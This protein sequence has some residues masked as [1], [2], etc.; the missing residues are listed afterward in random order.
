MI[1]ESVTLVAFGPYSDRTQELAPG[2]NVICGLNESGKSTWHA[3]VYAALC[4]ISRASGRRED[5]EFTERH[6]PWDQA[7]WEVR[8]VVKLESGRR[9]ELVQKLDSSAPSQALDL[10]SGDD[11]SAEIL[12][13]GAPDGSR[14]LGF[15]RRSFRS[16]ACVAQADVLALL[17]EPALLQ[18]QLTRA[19]STAGVESSSAAASERLDGLAA[20]VES[21][22]EVE[23]ERRPRL[24]ADVRQAKAVLA[25]FWAQTAVARDLRARHADLERDLRVLEAAVAMRVA[26]E[27]AHRLARVRELLDRFPERPQTNPADAD[28]LAQ[29]VA[30][31]IRAFEDRPE[32]PR[33]KGATVAELQHELDH[34]PEVAVEGDV[35][36]HPSVLAAREAYDG[37]KRALDENWA[38]RPPEPEPLLASAGEEELRALAD[39]LENE[40]PSGSASSG[41]GGGLMG[42]LLARSARSGRSGAAQQAELL[43]LPPHP[44]ALRA[45]AD[46]VARTQEMRSDLQ[47]WAT[48]QEELRGVVAERESD[49][50][51]A[52][53]A[54]GVSVEGQHILETL[55]GYIHSCQE[56]A[57]TARAEARRRELKDMIQARQ[58]ADRAAEVAEETRRRA[59]KALREV[60]VRCGLEGDVDLALL[61]GLHDWLGRHGE[62][63]EERLLCYQAWLELDTLIGSASVDEIEAASQ[64]NRSRALELAGQADTEQLDQ[65]VLGPEADTDLD[66]L[67]QAVAAALDELEAAEARTEEVRAMLAP[68]PDA[69]EALAASDALSS[70]LR[71]IGAAATTAYDHL[72]LAQERVHRSVAPMLASAVK[73]WLPAITNGRYVD[74]WVQPET[75]QVDVCGTDRNWRQATVLSHGT[76]EQIYLLL[77]LAMVERL[78]EPGERA[79]VLLDDVT[80][81]SDKPRTLA[82]LELLHQVSRERQVILFSQ[83]DDVRAWAES[84]LESRDRLLDLDAPGVPATEG[85]AR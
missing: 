69:E 43:G 11:I 36:P 64:R 78:T 84:H 33:P 40:S 80:V 49:L 5:R 39:Q 73:Q 57:A 46:H 31:A 1:I 58:E 71:E 9:V 44:A 41:P 67:R 77:R 47:R 56:R 6:R 61:A 55:F 25:E 34:L 50:S 37:A 72:A 45:A 23:R 15:N 18:E 19:A 22:L 10:A 2:F 28:E 20:A 38:Q 79:P 13:E 42:R 59:E 60:A 62:E 16:T 68:I 75:L 8:A 66:H 7:G 82:L 63:R 52:L 26:E 65:T 17:R 51:Q 21:A 53:A 76:A 48:R 14:F 3:G 24:E 81:Q 35:E 83:E 12:F 30:V 32:A 29:E 74:V 70:R 27:S 4:G 54:R 85:A